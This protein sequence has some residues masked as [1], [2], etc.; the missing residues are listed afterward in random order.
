MKTPVDKKIRHLVASKR[1]G[2]GYAIPRRLHR[3]L[4]KI[5]NGVPSA[6]KAIGDGAGI[7]AVALLLLSL[8]GCFMH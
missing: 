1:L 6:D 5:W 7:I 2:N 4:L 3:A 8:A